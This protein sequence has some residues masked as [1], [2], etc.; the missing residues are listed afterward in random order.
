VSAIWKQRDG[1][2]INVRVMSDDHLVNALAMCMRNRDNPKLSDKTRAAALYW[3]DVLASELR[4]RGHDDDDDDF[5]FGGLD[6][7]GSLQ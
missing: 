7:Y 1:T 5:C 4:L 6:R 3:I 2:K